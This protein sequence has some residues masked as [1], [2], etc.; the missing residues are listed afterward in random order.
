MGTSN[1]E[2]SN[3][4]YA[5]GMTFS[6]LGKLLQHQGLRDFAATLIEAARRLQP[7]GEE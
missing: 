5:M 2:L 4:L 6:E 7:R 3:E 1:A